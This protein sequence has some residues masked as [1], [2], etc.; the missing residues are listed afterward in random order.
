M[1]FQC[2]HLLYFNTSFRK[3][4][5]TKKSQSKSFFLFKKDDTL[6]QVQWWHSQNQG[7]YSTPEAFLFKLRNGHYWGNVSCKM[8][9][10]SRK[11][12]CTWG[13]ASWRQCND[14]DWHQLKRDTACS[15]HLSGMEV[16]AVL[17]FVLSSFFSIILIPIP[18]SFP[19][20]ISFH[21]SSLML[22]QSLSPVIFYSRNYLDS[23]IF[24]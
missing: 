18:S 11:R 10:K 22:T 9:L 3:A 8:V 6:L 23:S 5:W 4:M 12:W 15:S 1:R 21:C 2:I 20:P 14:T 16:W 24:F 7:N 19:G 13:W 17:L